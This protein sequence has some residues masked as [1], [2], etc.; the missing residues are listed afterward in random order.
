MGANLGDLDKTVPVSAA[1]TASLIYTAF[2]IETLELTWHWLRRKLIGAVWSVGRSLN[3]LK[4]NG[5]VDPDIDPERGS[6]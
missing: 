4:W 5:G 3:M 1:I 6:A 2:R